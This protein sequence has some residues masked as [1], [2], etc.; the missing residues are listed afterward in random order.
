MPKRNM[1]VKWS[2]TTTV[3]AGGV[4]YF[5]RNL[6]VGTNDLMTMVYEVKH[7]RGSTFYLDSDLTLRHRKARLTSRN[8]D[9]AGREALELLAAWVR[10]DSQALMLA[11]VRA[12]TVPKKAHAPKRKKLSAVTTG[13]NKV[14]KRPRY[15]AKM[16]ELLSPHERFDPHFQLR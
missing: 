5:G 14:A 3:W 10:I 9:D 11:L 1:R 15:V 16:R 12:Q 6:L 4:A 2:K 7:S 13:R 8:L